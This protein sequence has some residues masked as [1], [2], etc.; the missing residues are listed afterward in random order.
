MNYYSFIKIKEILPF[1]TTWLNLENI[2]LSE[3]SQAEKDKYCMILLYVESRKVRLR[4]REE[5]GVYQG[6]GGGKMGRDWS[7]STHFQL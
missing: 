1:T 3:V 2:F 4:T 6:L 5:S 7:Q